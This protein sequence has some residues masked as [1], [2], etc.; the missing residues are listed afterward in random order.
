MK[1]TNSQNEAIN[2]RGTNII[3]SAGA[4][5]GKTAV[6][7]ERVGKLVEDKFVEDIDDLLVLTFTK[8]AAAEMKERI[9]KRIKE[10]NNLSQNDPNRQREL[11]NKIDTCQITTFDAFALYIV[12]KYHYL[13]G[14]SKDVNIIDE[15]IFE[16]KLLIL[17]GSHA[18]DEREL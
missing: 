4:G 17:F 1:W 6:L 5:S 16:I 15:N 10:S 3:V 8:A 11:L 7:K 12:K 2:K 18:Y 13:L 9:K 14:M